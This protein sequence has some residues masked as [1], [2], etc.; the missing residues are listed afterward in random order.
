MLDKLVENPT[1][2]TIF[3]MLLTALAAFLKGTVRSGA[4]EDKRFSELRADYEKRLVD[5]REDFD[6]RLLECTKLA[7]YER[8]RADRWTEIATQGISTTVQALR[9]L[10]QGERR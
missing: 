5:L 2:A 3:V 4:A 9:K 1:V 6:E 7:E 10:P 8:Q